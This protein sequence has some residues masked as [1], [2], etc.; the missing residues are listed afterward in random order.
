MH[1]EELLATG[2]YRSVRQG[3]PSMPAFSH[4]ADRQTVISVFTHACFCLSVCLS[5]AA[6]PTRA[7]V[8]ALVEAGA[9]P[10]QRCSGEEEPPS[11]ASA[12]KQALVAFPRTVRYRKLSWGE[13]DK[14]VK[15]W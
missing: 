13:E 8:I 2:S 7:L 14:V 6:G 5:E 1:L 4:E 12:R 11:D 10:L 3:A 9:M 15:G